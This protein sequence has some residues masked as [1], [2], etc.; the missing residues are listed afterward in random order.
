M[1]IIKF[2]DTVEQRKTVIRKAAAS[3]HLLTFIN[4]QKPQ[5]CKFLHNLW[6]NQGNAITYKAIRE[7]ILSGDITPAMVESWQQD[8]SRFV[9]EHILPT[10]EKSFKEAALELERTY[11]T[12]SFDGTAVGVR[13][14]NATNAARFVTNVNTEQ[15]QGLRA[16]IRRATEL[17]ADG[18]NVDELSR[19]I[20]PMVGLTERQARANLNY[21]QKLIDN[22][23][24]EKKA[25]EMSI[26]YSAKQHRYR[27]Q[28]IARTEIAFSYNQGEYHSVKQAQEQNLMGKCRK[29]WVTADTERTCTYCDSMD[30]QIIEMDEDFYYYKNKRLPDGRVVRVRERINPNLKGEKIGKCPPAHPQCMCLTVYIEVEPPAIAPEA[31]TTTTEEDSQPEGDYFTPAKSIKEANEYAQNVLGIPHADYKGTTV[32]IANEWNRGLADNFRRFPELR[33]NFDFVGTCQNRNKLAKKELYPYVMDKF[34]RLNPGYTEKQ[35]EKAVKQHITKKYAPPISSHV[36]AQSCK[37]GKIKGVTI[38][39]RWQG[40]KFLASIKEDVVF[41][42]HPQGCDTIRS[43]LDHEIGHQI[44]DMLD[45]WDNVEIARLYRSMTPGEMTNSLSRYA[46]DNSNM[47]KEREFVAEAWA[48]YVNNPEPREV[49]RKVGEIIEEEYRKFK[50]RQ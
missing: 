45:L 4:N 50:A 25:K 8:Y 47:I 30:G 26:K 18:M 14:W 3:T 40:E 33:D 6:N 2:N 23:V 35:L 44:D 42:F 9:T 16:V 29:Q 11:P 37:T 13:E 17:A 41:K 21:Y 10:W 36:Y 20:R 32:E 7:A 28:M 38:S 12:F 43:I 46:W 5:L 27:A 1:P 31:T 49:A 48:E 24:K 19:V 34:K 15:I 22:G 39:A